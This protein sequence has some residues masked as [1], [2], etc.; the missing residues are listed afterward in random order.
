MNGRHLKLFFIIT[1]FFIVF[2]LK[3][4]TINKVN[5]IQKKHILMLLKSFGHYVK[6]SKE[7]I[8]RLK[9]IRK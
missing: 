3:L 7:K 6:E 4:L 5:I 8:E 2:S 1:M 9:N